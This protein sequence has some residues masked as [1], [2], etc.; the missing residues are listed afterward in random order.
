MLAWRKDQQGR[1]KDLNQ[2]ECHNEKAGMDEPRR[3]E[4]GDKTRPPRI[5]PKM[6]IICGE[7]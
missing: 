1:P 4:G 5:H 7:M 3:D 6:K 2:S